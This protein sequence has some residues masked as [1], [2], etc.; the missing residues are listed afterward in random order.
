MH[1][2]YRDSRNFGCFLNSGSAENVAEVLAE[3]PTHQYLV[4]PTTKT[5]KSNPLIC[6]SCKHGLRVHAVD[7]LWC[8][9][10]DWRFPVMFLSKL[11]KHYFY[12][13]VQT[14]YGT[15]PAPL[16]HFFKI[17]LILFIVLFGF[18]KLG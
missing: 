10:A 8:E 4:S 17:S 11:R 15:S 12:C 16:H 7:R 5:Q 3:V 13:S 1:G 18:G 9:L 2:T 14:E 6:I